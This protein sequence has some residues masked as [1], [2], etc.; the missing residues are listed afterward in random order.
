[1]LHAK[2]CFSNRSRKKET[3]FSFNSLIVTVHIA[4]KNTVT[5]PL[6]ALKNVHAKCRDSKTPCI[7]IRIFCILRFVCL[8]FGLKSIFSSSAGVCLSLTSCFAALLC[9]FSFVFFFYSKTE[10]YPQA[11]LCMQVL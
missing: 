6:C 1:M 9:F 7:S 10:V 3:L 8:H 5:L 4:K 2:E 11:L